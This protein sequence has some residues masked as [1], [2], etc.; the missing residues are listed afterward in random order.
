VLEEAKGSAIVPEGAENSPVRTYS[1]R[2]FNQVMNW[3]L[4]E[5][6]AAAGCGHLALRADISGASRK[7]GCKTNQ[8]SI[9]L[10]F[11]V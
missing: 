2:N 8:K 6:I 9:S 11:S 1:R 7:A 10:F 3:G 4:V 5:I